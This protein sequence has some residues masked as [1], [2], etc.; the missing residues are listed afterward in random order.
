MEVILKQDVK[1]LGKK[2]SMVKVS[3]GY[4]KNFLIPRGLAI[5]ATAAN[6]NDMKLKQKAA[7]DKQAREL[8]AGKETAANLEGKTF[9]LKVKCGENGKL[10]GAISNKDVADMIKKDLGITIDKKKINIDEPIKQLGTYDVKVRVMAGVTAMIKVIV[11][12]L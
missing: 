6:I 11:A 4:A 10:F 5:P 2:D 12:A 1:E 9:T 7:A 3:D 8:A